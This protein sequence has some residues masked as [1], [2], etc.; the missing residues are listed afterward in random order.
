M[1]STKI[2]RRIINAEIIDTIIVVFNCLFNC[3]LLF[4]S[5]FFQEIF[6]RA[7]SVI[8]ALLN[9][10]AVSS[11]LQALHED[12]VFYINNIRRN[13]LF[14]KDNAARIEVEVNTQS[15]FAEEVAKLGLADR[16]DDMQ[17]IIPPS[18]YIKV[19]IAIQPLFFSI[20]PLGAHNDDVR[21]TERRDCVK[22]SVLDVV[23]HIFATL[24][25][26]EEHR[27]FRKPCLSLLLSLSLTFLSKTFLVHYPHTPNDKGEEECPAEDGT[28]KECPS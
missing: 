8:F 24:F 6:V 14:F 23:E 13:V 21:A 7:Q 27:R 5:C 10:P 1:E 17:I 19:S 28:K 2:I 26:S 3:C 25:R 4:C 12:I 11:R 20:I 9:L 22:T 18:A 16:G 15:F